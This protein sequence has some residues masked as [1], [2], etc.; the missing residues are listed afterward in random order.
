MVRLL[1]PWFENAGKRL[2]KTPKFYVRDSGLFHALLGLRDAKALFQH[3][4]LGA[5]WEGFAL[6]ETL[7]RTGDR[8]AYFWNT[9]GGAELDLLVSVR[10][11]RIGF[12]F[13]YA[14]APAMTRSLQVA[15]ADLKL[16]RAFVVHPG[17][18]S[19]ALNGWAQ[20]LSIEDLL[21]LKPGGAHPPINALPA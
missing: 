10:G 2:V 13:K 19:Y 12:E 16:H 9:Q 7:R 21:T 20:A 4:K 1:S 8:E 14:D 17:P 18:K 5:S 3:P 11:E 15:K 6:E